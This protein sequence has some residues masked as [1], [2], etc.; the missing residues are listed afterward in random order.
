[1]FDT[2]AEL[3]LLSHAIGWRGVLA[4]LTTSPARKF[5]EGQLRGRVSAGY[6]ADIVILGGDPAEGIER[7]GD[8]RL[9]L[10]DGVEIYAQRGSI[11]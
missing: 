5:G 10:K 11:L 8:V 4:S 9:V 3:R 1:M 2:S 6:K 7:F